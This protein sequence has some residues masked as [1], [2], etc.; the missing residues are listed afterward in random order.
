MIRRACLLAGI[1]AVFLQGSNG[2]HML[3]VEHARCA[4]HGELVH[5]GEGH[6]RETGGHAE[7]DSPTFQNSSSDR[8]EEAHEHCAFSADRRNAL[9]A[10]GGGQLSTHAHE[11][12]IDLA[13]ASVFVCSGD[14]RFRIA[15]KNSPPA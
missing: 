8:P 15:P 6:H 4:E 11:T 10:I 9:I 7:S 13:L 14:A 5:N 3:L 1:L 2:G 12:R